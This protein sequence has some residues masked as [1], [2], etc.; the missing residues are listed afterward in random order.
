MSNDVIV[1]RGPSLSTPEP[2][3]DGVGA[4]ILGPRNLPRE[5]ENPDILVPP[6]TDHGTV[7]NLRWSFADSRMRLCEGGWARQTTVRELGIAKEIAGVNMRLEKGAVRE[8][9]FHQEAEW[10]YVLKGKARISAVDRGRKTFLD[11][12]KEGDLWFFAKG[13]PHSI[14]GLE[15]DGTEFLLC[16]DDG[17][18]NENATVLLTDWLAHT[19]REVL[20]KN[21]GVPEKAFDHIPDH[22]LYIFLTQL[23]PPLDQDRV[24]GAG[25]VSPWLSFP[26]LAQEPIRTTGGK[27]WIAD[28]T[29][30]H[31]SKTIA[32]ALN[33]VEPG[34]LR[35][36]HWH[37]NADEW[38]YFVSGKARMTVFIPD[39]NAATYDYQAGDVG[40]VPR[41]MP[42]YVENTGDTTMRFLEVFRSDHFEDMSLR[43]WL[44]L[45]PHELVR[46]HLHIDESVLTKYGPG[47]MPI[48]PP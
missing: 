24:R 8:L 32:A 35:E 12:V 31:A 5:A 38:Q 15:D 23:P 42:H 25:L 29:N 45:T 40:Y 10:A 28:S 33:E 18:F 22:E 13:V 26:L 9:H 48:L 41:N 27:V 36:L 16:F 44:E 1:R 7:P 47:R 39:G 4:N 46:A 6:K 34:G 17:N 3:R 20:A 11:D 37:G 43:N 30:F 14:Q 19:P 2:I 21:F